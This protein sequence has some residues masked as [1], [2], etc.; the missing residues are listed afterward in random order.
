MLTKRQFAQVILDEF[1][2]IKRGPNRY[3]RRPWK[4]SMAL[5][6]TCAGKAALFLGLVKDPGIIDYLQQ[7]GGTLYFTSDD[8]GNSFFLTMDE[9]L[10]LLPED[11]IDRLRRVAA[12]HLKAGSGERLGNTCNTFGHYRN[13]RKCVRCSR[14]AACLSKKYEEKP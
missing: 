11:K 6:S 4:D 5:Q 14:R 12:K 7:R 1:L 9:M 10:G 8:H 3:K 2:T 13:T